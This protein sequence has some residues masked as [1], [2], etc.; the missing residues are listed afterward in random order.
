MLAGLPQTGWARGLKYSEGFTRPVPS[1][2]TIAG[3]LAW[4]WLLGLAM[5]DLIAGTAYAVWVGIGAVG[6][7]FACA[8][9]LQ[10]PL[11]LPRVAGVGLI[12]AGIVTLKLAYG[13]KVRHPRLGPDHRRRGDA[14]H[15][16]HSPG[17][18]H[19]VAYVVPQGAPNFHVPYCL[20]VRNA[21]D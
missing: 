13:P 1:G 12:L 8:V 15:P 7:V 19:R 10:E 5:K 16:R 6:T 20:D 21:Q 2:P 14:L 4:L 17:F 18:R 9:F 11:N 3:A